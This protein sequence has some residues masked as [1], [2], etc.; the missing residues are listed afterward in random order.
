MKDGGSV[1]PLKDLVLPQP[2]VSLRDAFVMIVLWKFLAPQD[3]D[4][5]Q[6][7]AER[8]YALADELIRARDAR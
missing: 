4:K 3:L 1:F 7:A 2:G 5:P 6:S 8:A